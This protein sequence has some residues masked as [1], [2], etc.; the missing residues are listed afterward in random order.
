[1]TEKEAKLV[2]A[3]FDPQ[4]PIRFF[5]RN[6]CS[7]EVFGGA[8]ADA[9]MLVDYSEWADKA[10]FNSYI[11]LNPTRKLVGT[12]CR[13]EDITNW[14]WFMLDID[15]VLPYA[16]PMSTLERAEDL[17]KAQF[18]LKELHR[19]LIDS[20]RGV[21]AWY[22][23]G[24]IPTSEIF[25]AHTDPL[26]RSFD[27]KDVSDVEREMKIGDAAPR[28]MAY[29]LG[30]LF[31]RMGGTYSGCNIDTSVSDLP[32]VMRLPF[33]INQKTGRRTEIKET[34]SL[35]NMSLASKLLT[36]A[37][38]KVWKEKPAVEALEGALWIMY[39]PHMTRGGRVFLTEGAEEPGRHRAASAAMLSLMD[40]GC[41]Y[42]QIKAALRFGGQLCTP[43]LP[44]SETDD[45]I[46]RRMKCRA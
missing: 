26:P 43:V 16:D 1:M 27:L 44:S 8:V 35:K 33:T 5:A 13:A 15:P 11:Q 28:A 25:K 2:L 17:L 6:P 14:S 39:L 10:K 30:W 34:T 7:Q 24:P 23:L 3:L 4:Y 45:M 37:P 36:Y 9:N 18:G 42:G 32:R 21:Q 22:P 38:Y 12:R 19:V 46:K 41:D 29:W 31:E 20:A 40:L